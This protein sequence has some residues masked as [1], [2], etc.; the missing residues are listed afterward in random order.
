MAEVAQCACAG[1]YVRVQSEARVT[2]L[3]REANGAPAASLALE[4]V[5]VPEHP[6]DEKPQLKVKRRAKLILRH[7]LLRGGGICFSFEND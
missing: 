7:P 4:L 1:A 5:A 6:M 3:V 2:G